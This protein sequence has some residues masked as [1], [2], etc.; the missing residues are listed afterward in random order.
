MFPLRK[1]YMRRLMHEVGFQHIETYGDFLETYKADDPDFFVH[2][3]EK[4][5]RDDDEEEVGADG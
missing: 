3:A 2:V 1:K 4:A 5:Y